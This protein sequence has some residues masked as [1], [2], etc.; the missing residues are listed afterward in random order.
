MI[1]IPPGWSVTNELESIELVHPGGRDVA[2]IEYRERVRPL[3]KAGAIVR[4]FLAERAFRC[5]ELP[6]VVERLTTVEGEYASQV[7]LAGDDRGRP[8]Q[9]DLGIVFGD[10]FYARLAAIC[11]RSELYDE[12]TKLVHDLV[13][14][15][16]HVLGMRRRRFEYAPPRGW[17][18]IVRGFVTDWLAPEY[19]RDAV[20]LTVYP[21]NPLALAPAKLV[22]M[23]LGANR[24]DAR[25]DRQTVVPLRTSVGLAGELGDAAVVVGERRLVK[26]CA[27]LH[28]T[29]FAYALE[30]TAGTDDQLATHRADLE[31][32]FDSVQPLPNPFDHVREH[33]YAAQS[34]WIE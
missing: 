22:A 19:P 13:V 9:C 31:H 20:L 27:V 17:Q 33:D 15:D 28:D 21:A 5:S 34:Y 6:D 11:Y 16:V 32:V 3:A 14:G 4:R 25:F 30:A 8:A 23:L 26:L 2:V 29:R 10:D 18:P 1:V 24:P 12:L 7:T